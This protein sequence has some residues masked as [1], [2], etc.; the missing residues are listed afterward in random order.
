LIFLVVVFINSSFPDFIVDGLENKEYPYQNSG[1]GFHKILGYIFQAFAE[2]SR[3]SAVQYEQH[4]HG[5]F[6]GMMNGRDWRKA[7]FNRT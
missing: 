3:C 2:G 5:V 6:K 4:A 7:V 1:L